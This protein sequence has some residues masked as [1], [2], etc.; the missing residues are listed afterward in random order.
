VPGAGIGGGGGGIIEQASAGAAKNPM[1]AAIAAAIPILPSLFITV[2]PDT[3]L[4]TTLALRQTAR[5]PSRTGQ[6]AWNGQ[7]LHG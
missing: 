7:S 2:S 5:K 4:W 3:F 6:P 1:A